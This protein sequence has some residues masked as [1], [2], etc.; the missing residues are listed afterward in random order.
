MLWFITFC[1]EKF[2]DVES[3]TSYMHEGKFL[4]NCSEPYLC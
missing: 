1:I 2:Y 4:Y 3:Q